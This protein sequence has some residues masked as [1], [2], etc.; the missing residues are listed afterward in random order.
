MKKPPFE[1]VLE[2]LE[3]FELK[4]KPMFG[5]YGVYHDSKILMILRKKTPSD[6][7]TGIWFGIPDELINDIKAEFPILQNLT[8]FGTPPT[9]WQV[10]RES[11][12]DFE[13]TALQL[14]SLMKKKDKRIGRIP[15][16]KPLKKKKPFSPPER[17]KTKK[18]KK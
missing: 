18:K 15:K 3:P 13:E 11:E 1:F 5:A 14:C 9:A 8:L 10:L 2:A 12:V 4:I 6:L 16:P 7:D 17:I